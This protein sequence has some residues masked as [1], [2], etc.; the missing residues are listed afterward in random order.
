MYH[1]RRADS[2]FR[3][4][5]NDRLARLQIHSERLQSRNRLA[6]R[7][8]LVGNLAEQPRGRHG[9]ARVVRLRPISAEEEQ[10][11]GGSGLDGNFAL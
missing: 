1:F 3:F 2:R 7:T 10:V 8:E 9:A 11:T 6:R 5:V 4:R